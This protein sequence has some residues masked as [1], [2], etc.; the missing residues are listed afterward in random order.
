[1]EYPGVIPGV[2]VGSG[3]GQCKSGR[4]HGPRQPI[5]NETPVNGQRAGVSENWPVQDTISG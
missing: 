3:V 1:M 2:A 5:V 4:Q